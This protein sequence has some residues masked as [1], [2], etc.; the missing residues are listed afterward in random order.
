MHCSLCDLPTPA[1]P[2]E[3]DGYVFC[4]FGCMEVYRN[5]GADIL[6]GRS[7]GPLRS[8]PEIPQ[9]R[10]GK[11]AFLRV[12]GMH[13]SSCE[14]LIDRM[15]TATDGILS[16][17]S[18]YATSTA[19]VVY[20]PD[21]VTEAE[22]PTIVSRFGYRA[23]LSGDDRP[24]Y[25]NRF[26]LLRLLTG[27]VFWVIVMMLYVAFFYPSH[28]GL[29]DPADLE[30]IGWLAFGAAPWAMFCV[31]TAMM[32]YVGAPIFRGALIGLHAG[33]LN[34]DNLL[35]IAILAAYGYSTGQLLSGSLDLYFDVANTIV[36]VV[37]LGRYLERGAKNEATHELSKIMEAWAPKARIRL[38]G[39]F[40]L[41]DIDA[42]EAGA[43]VIVM[44]GEAI[45]VDGTILHGGGAID[46]S[47]LTGEPV[48]AR[49]MPGEAVL[50]G[51][52]LVE[53]RLEIAVGPVARNRMEDLAR[54]LWNA[55]SGKSGVRALADRVARFFRSIGAVIGGLCDRADPFDRCRHG[56]RIA[57]RIGH[58]D[59]FLSL[60]IRAGQSI[61]D[62]GR[63]QH[64]LAPGHHCHQ[65]RHI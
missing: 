56:P 52:I 13:C 24:E 33:V 25:D 31:T 48:P 50:G 29:V 26:D 40:R 49:R 32:A 4:C 60:H 42:L 3:S 51:T 43:R 39:G 62:G 20:D 30:P 46:E 22:L 64:C 38:G 36:A 44:D 57:G 59:R 21:V 27:L 15:A 45:P 55:Q 23:W 17:E 6:R 11:E 28:L 7:V 41:V 63:R 9:D 47:L 1:S 5:F 12:D 53:G 19:K 65:R 8:V 2:F 54:I 58:L 14:Y 34:M 35:A 16:T 10:P 18:S 37:T 61:D